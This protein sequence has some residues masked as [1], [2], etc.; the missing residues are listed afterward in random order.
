MGAVADYIRALQSY[1]EYAFSTEELYQKTFAP[2]STVKK[3]LARLIAD[4]QL[5]NLRKGFYVIIPP[6]YQSYNRLPIEL[7][8]DKLFTYLDRPYYVSLYSAA[9]LHGASHQKV[10]QDYIMTSLPALRDIEKNNTK[11]NFFTRTKWPQANV[12]QRSSTAGYFNVSSPA[13][14]FADL[15][16]DQNHLGGINRMLAILEELSEAI[17]PSDLTELLSWY[18]EKS[19]LQRM[20]YLLE[21]MQWKKQLAD[22]ILESLQQHTFFPILLSPCR[23]QKAGSTGNRWKID[24]NVELESDL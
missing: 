8:V 19:T 6:S 10:Q 5:I 11:I 21:E 16:S 22:I 13:L 1:E 18:K 24:A 9:T 12:L 2:G 15:L 20:G 3:E 4:N 7:Y 17:E 23:N 14:T